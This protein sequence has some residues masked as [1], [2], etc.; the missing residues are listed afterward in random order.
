MR[1]SIRASSLLAV[2]APALLPI[3]ARAQAAL[4]AAKIAYVDTRYILNG[5]PATPTVQAAMQKE[6]QAGEAQAKRM[7]DSL[8]MLTTNFSKA[9]ATM[10]AE[11]R[12]AQLKLINDRQGEYQ[13]RYSAIQQQLQEREAELMQPI[14]DQIK[15][16]L[17]DV[18]TE[19]GLTMI[20]DIA[21]GG[22]LVA[23]DKNLNISDRV[24]AKL[25]TMPVPTVAERPAVDPKAAGKAAPPP[26]GPTNAPAGIARP[27]STPA[28]AAA[29][30]KKADSAAT[31]KADSAA[32]K[33][34]D[35][36]GTK[37]PDSAATK[38]P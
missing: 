33:R 24:L 11:R 35:S 17:E 6:V 8:D 31:K 14:L 13:G 29:S 23:A 16:A 10:S 21:Q 9:Q 38:R 28:P 15:L 32:T 2:F 22:L 37:R 34:P 3:A 19:M 7:S 26:A 36:T 18:R 25:R 4:P 30:T 5:S 27:G 20:L 12:D 1:A